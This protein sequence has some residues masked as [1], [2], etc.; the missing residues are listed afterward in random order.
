MTSGLALGPITRFTARAWKAIWMRPFGSLLPTVAPPP[1]RLLS[2]KRYQDPTGHH[3]D[4]DLFAYPQAISGFRFT[5]H[6]M[7]GRK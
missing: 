1:N 7:H 6:L 5:T 3:D 4:L 2:P